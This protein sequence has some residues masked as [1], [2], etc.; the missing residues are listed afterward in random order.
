M[1][2][3]AILMDL[4]K[5]FDCLPYSLLIAKLRAYGLSEGAVKLLD[6]YLEDRSQQ[7]RL[8]THASS[9]KKLFKG[10]PRGSISGPL[11]F[12]AFINTIFTSFFNIFYITTRMTILYLLY[13]K[14]LHFLNLFRTRK[15]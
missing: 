4:S 5:A 12:N 8:G 11:L 10:V 9:G 15:Q 3:G 6:I 2:V 1:C 13:T 7:I 14:T